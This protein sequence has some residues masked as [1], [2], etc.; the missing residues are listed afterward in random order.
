MLTFNL[1]RVFALRGITDPIPFMIEAG[2]IRQTANNLFKQQTSIVKIE[3]LDVLCRLLN[4]TPND[5]FEWQGG[6]SSLSESHS[7]NSLRRTQTAQTIKEMVKDIPL[8]KVEKLIDEQ[9]G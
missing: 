3:H 1:K 2:I 7:L 5:F 9:N 8:G 6:A 4:C